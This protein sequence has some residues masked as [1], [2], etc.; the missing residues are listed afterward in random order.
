VLNQLINVD[1]HIHSKASAYKEP[2]GLVSECD[3]EHS[4]VLLSALRENNI[5]LFS[6][7]DHNRFDD[8]LYEALYSKIESVKCPGFCS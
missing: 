1:L 7:T 6:I 4:H 2:K 3:S 8:Q 5:T